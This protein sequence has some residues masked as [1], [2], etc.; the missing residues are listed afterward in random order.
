MEL[1]IRD[2]LILIGVLLIVAVLLDA[3]R[4]YRQERSSSI[5]MARMSFGAGGGFECEGPE[6]Y[7]SELPGGG[8]RVLRREA[9]DSPESAVGL[10]DRELPARG[11][12]PRVEPRIGAGSISHEASAP[13]KDR[14]AAM[15]VSEAPDSRPSRSPVRDSSS[16]PAPAAA[17]DGVSPQTAAADRSSFVAPKH[18]KAIADDND[19]VV[20]NVLAKDEQGFRGTDLL[21]I[22][23]ACDVRYGDMNIFHRHEGG[24][25]EGQVQFSI[26]N[27]VE[28][29]TFDLDRIND[30]CTPGII[31]FM[32]MPGPEDPAAAYDCM[33]ETARCIVKN[34]GGSLSDGKLC[35]VTAQTLKQDRARIN[36]FARRSMATH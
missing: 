11:V 13:L 1:G 10:R 14:I 35:T 18:D 9:S 22:L 26:A 30:F 25:G 28:P 15:Q 32:R 31:F 33:L 12:E 4:R 36:E 16:A 24:H 17:D 19:V 23:L 34:L 3:F 2:W 29:G 5:R 6:V 8:A 7:G 27:A 21:E 20:L